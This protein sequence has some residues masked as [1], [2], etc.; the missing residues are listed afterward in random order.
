VEL[1][2][3]KTYR[4]FVCEGSKKQPF[5]DGSLFFQHTG[6]SPLKFNAQ[7]TRKVALCTYKTTQ[8]PP[9]CDGTH[10]SE[11]VQKAEVGS[12]SE[13]WLLPSPRW[14][15]FQ[16]SDRHYPLGKELTA[17]PKGL[18]LARQLAVVPHFTICCWRTWY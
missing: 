4:W 13:G 10:K 12:Y 16:V 1:V 2:A 3:R 11:Q 5:C 18:Q 15:C 14:L 7:E 6:L 9:Y 8:K 17:E